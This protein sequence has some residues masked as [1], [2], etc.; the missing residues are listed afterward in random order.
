MKF[1]KAF[2][3]LATLAIAAVAIG[4]SPTGSTIP[5]T[6]AAGATWTLNNGVVLKNGVPFGYSQGVTL[7]LYQ[8]GVVYQ[9][10]GTKY[11]A[12]S[13]TQ[14]WTLIPDP[15]VSSSSS[16]S[17]G[18]SSTSSSSSSSSSG[19]STSSSSSSSSSGTITTFGIKTKGN[20]FVD[21]NGA[22]LQLQGENVTGLSEG[23]TSMWDAFYDTPASTWQAAASKWHM[24]IIRLPVAEYNWNNNSTSAK[25]RHYQDIVA[26]A[27]ANIIAAHMYPI[28]D[29]HS[30]SPNAYQNG[31]HVDRPGYADKDNSI[32]FW[33]S[34]A[35][36]YKSNPA[37][38]FEL[39]NEPVADEPSGAW[40]A[41]RLSLLLH[42]SDGGAGNFPLWMFVN[43][44]FS[45][46]G[47]TFNV[48]G[49][50]QLLD[51]IR[52]TGATNVILYP[53][54]SWD[55]HPAQSLAVKPTD[56]LG[57]LGA[58]IHYSGGNQSD[59]QSILIAGVPILETEYWN[60]VISGNSGYPWLKQNHIGYVM[61]GANNWRSAGTLD[62]I[63]NYAPWDNSRWGNNGHVAWQ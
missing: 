24:N 37:V 1:L 8:G 34:V 16:S 3:A 26:K 4:E 62:D 15:H 55:N 43:G 53:C 38:L 48:A 35:A 28:I 18:G 56:P 63:V 5:I 45:N 21:L 40:N 52:A 36:V 42:G 32:R 54:P 31:S 46:T 58:T 59:W 30:A 14:T 10:A 9:M 49:N 22:V 61:W 11:W 23:S 60:P 7:L 44:N 50:Q 33:S 39:F 27:V 13:G 29:L 2:T 47:V 17:S 12:A 25:G 20:T 41:T 6:D 57:Q 19:S 51:A